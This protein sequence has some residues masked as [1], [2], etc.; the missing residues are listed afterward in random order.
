[1][2]QIEAVKKVGASLSSASKLFC[3]SPHAGNHGQAAVRLP[4]GIKDIAIEIAK[5]E[6][7]ACA[8][9]IELVRDDWVKVDANINACAADYL[10]Q[11]IRARSNAALT[12]AAKVD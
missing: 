11:A 8:K 9:C 5:A 2:T 4:P 10:A 12:G 3:T 6:R 1:M 7:E